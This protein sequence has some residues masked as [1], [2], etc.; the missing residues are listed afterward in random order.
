MIEQ[1]DQTA[2]GRF[3]S[4]GWRSVAIAGAAAATG[5]VALVALRDPAPQGARYAVGESQDGPAVDDQDPLRAELARCRTLAATADDARC[6]AAWEVN[7]RRF[8]G[9][10]R[11]FIAPG[12]LAPVASP[13]P[14]PDKPSEP[15][16]TER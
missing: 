6:R 2:S 4:L 15:Q 11:S 13:V 1:R 7:R 5:I 8:M 12:D 10:S 3:A 16:A 14:V 9:E